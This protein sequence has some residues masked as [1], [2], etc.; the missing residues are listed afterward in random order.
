MPAEVVRSVVQE[1]ANTF[2]ARN[3]RAMTSLAVASA[4]YWISGMTEKVP[5]AGDLPYADRVQRIQ[6]VFSGMDTLDVDV[7]GITVEGDVGIL[8]SAPNGS[9]PGDRVY[10][11]NVLIKMVVQDGKIQDVREYVDAFALLNYL[12]IYV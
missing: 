4:N 7:L 6:T 3:Y 12:G 11:N 1:W 2:I 5:F 8:E 9:G 10:K